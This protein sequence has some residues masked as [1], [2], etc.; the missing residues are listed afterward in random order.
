MKLYAT[1]KVLLVDVGPGYLNLTYPAGNSTSKFQFLVS[2][3]AQ[4]Q[5]VTGWNDIQGLKVTASGTFDPKPN[6]TYSMD[7]GAIK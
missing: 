1:E 3:F 5:D 4:K 2:P 6:V 7:E